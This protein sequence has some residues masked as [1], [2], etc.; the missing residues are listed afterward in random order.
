M[1][2]RLAYM[3]QLDRRYRHQLRTER[4]LRQLSSGSFRM[5][6]ALPG[7]TMSTFFM[8]PSDTHFSSRPCASF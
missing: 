4:W 1:T 6:P 8:L 7:M 5:T 3:L 2:I